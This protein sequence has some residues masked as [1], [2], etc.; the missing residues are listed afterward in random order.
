MTRTGRT[1]K[2]RRRLSTVAAVA[3][4]ACLGLGVPSA[5]AY[6]AS[7]CPSER[8]WEDVDQFRISGGIPDFGDELHLGGAPQGTAV[9]CWDGNLA[10][11][12]AT[13]VFLKARLY[14]DGGGAGH[15]SDACA[16]AGISFL[17]GANAVRATRTR[18]VCG[19]S[20]LRSE[21]VQLFIV[22]LPVHRITINLF[23]H[24]VCCEERQLQR[25][26]S[27]IFGD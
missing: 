17:D 27:V 23:H 5:H 6:D 22:N 26:K 4:M 20:G 14:R 1:D 21:I 11:A 8:S 19:S 25:T 2:R 15:D 9:M 3:L 12:N 13:T 10:N 16:I 18:T 7:T 24:H